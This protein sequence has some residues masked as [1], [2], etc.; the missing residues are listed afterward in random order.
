MEKAYVLWRAF[1]E[2]ILSPVAALL[3]LAM[4]VLA[5]VEIVRRYIFGV[6]F[7]WQSDAVTFFMLS[8]VYLYF[9]ISQRRG[10][11]L[12]VT[13]VLETLE[14]IGPRSRRAAEMIRLLASIIAFGFILWLAYWGIPE[15]QDAV[16]YES[17]TESLAFPMWPFLTVLVAG[18]IF[19]AITLAFQ[20]YRSIQKLRGVSVLDEPPEEVPVLD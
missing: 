15:V 1:Q 6:S 19:M 11:H 4:T 14:P 13:L 9:G 8:A 20:I 17:R 10:E 12:T 3:M 16:R 5:I 18:F 7:E 2:R